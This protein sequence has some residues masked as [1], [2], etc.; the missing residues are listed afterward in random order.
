M[1]FPLLGK[2]KEV[3]RAGW[4][5]LEH[6]FLRPVWRVLLNFP[7]A[8]NREAKVVAADWENMEGV[9]CGQTFDYYVIDR[10]TWTKIMEDR[11]FRI[12]LDSRL[13]MRAL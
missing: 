9:M 3:A 10:D 6:A 2:N 1:N 8:A 12:D 5:A 4:L 13:R 7:K 11:D